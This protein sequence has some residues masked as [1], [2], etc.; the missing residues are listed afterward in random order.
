ME[1]YALLGLAHWRVGSKAITAAFRQEALKCHPD[2]V[3]AEAKGAA[4][5]KMQRLNAAREMLVDDRRRTQYHL[6]GTLPWAGW[7]WWWE[8][9]GEGLKEM[10]TG[11]FCF[12]SSCFLVND[13]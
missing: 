6:T 8:M 12:L 2:K 5:E 9:G 11:G 7:V 10:L 13:Y 4:T 1:A 3:A